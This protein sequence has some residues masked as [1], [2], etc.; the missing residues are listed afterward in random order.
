MFNFNDYNKSM[1][2]NFQESPR[3]NYDTIKSIKS[4]EHNNSRLNE[5]N[6]KNIFKNKLKQI[7]KDIFSNATK[8][9][10]IITRSSIK[11]KNT[12]HPNRNKNYYLKILDSI[13][14]ND[15]HLNQTNMKFKLNQNNTKI[16]TSIP[17]P[18]K[19]SKDKLVKDEDI[20]KENVKRN[21]KHSKRKES[22]VD[23]NNF[24]RNGI[25]RK[26]K[27]YNS[28]HQIIKL[29]KKINNNIAKYTEINKLKDNL[30][31]K[32]ITK[33]I[34]ENEEKGKNES[35]K[36]KDDNKSENKKQSKIEGINIEQENK[37]I[38]ENKMNDN[39]HYKNEEI[40]IKKMEYHNE[41]H[42]DKVI[43][44][45]NHV[46]TKSKNEIVKYTKKEKEKGKTKHRGFPL[47][48][49]IIKDDSS[50]NE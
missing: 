3:F 49:F 5:E 39:N 42:K 17:Y 11:H 19:I 38:N 25:K 10:N 34:K 41:N 29:K 7:D 27:K 1:C 24:D 26:T 45:I 43:V 32:T 31:E 46:E 16:S 33:K 6:G 23:G 15:S 13:Y 9:E 30:K 4:S 21:K 28:S 35:G 47:C 44:D 37:N 2:F 12:L 18:K 40:S 22:E 36:D 14:K 20:I 48:C 8:N 50:D